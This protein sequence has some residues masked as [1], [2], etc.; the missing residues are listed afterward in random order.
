MNIT[1]IFIDKETQ[2]EKTNNLNI[3]KEDI[4]CLYK[5]QFGTFV[6]TKSGKSYKVT[7]SFSELEASCQQL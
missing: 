2:E 5:D 3:P 6:T 4:G 1:V 7:Q